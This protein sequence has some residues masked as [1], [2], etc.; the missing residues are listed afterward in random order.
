MA[1]CHE[2]LDRSLGKLQVGIARSSD[3]SAGSRAVSAQAFAAVAGEPIAVEVRSLTKAYDGGG[4]LALDGVSLSI[5]RG[6]FFSLLGPSGCGKTT[7]LR[8]IGGFEQLTSGQVLIDGADVGFAPPYLRSTN[9]IFQHLALFPHMNVFENIAFGLRRKKVP[10]RELRER[11]GKALVLVQL[12]EYGSRMADQLSGGQKQ[13]VAMARAMV[14]EPS[15]LLLDE[16]LASLDLQLRIQM[17]DE[18]RRLHKSSGRTFIYVTHDQG[19]A[20]SMSNRIGVMRAGKLEQIGTPEEI[21]N[22]PRT[23]FVAA[24]VGHTNL[25]E[26]AVSRIVSDRNVEIDCRGT[27]FQAVSPRL[28]KLGQPVTVALRYERLKVSREAKNG[29]L[30]AVVV[31]RT[32][33]GQAVRLEMLVDNGPGLTAEVQDIPAA[34]AFAKGDRVSLAFDASAAV[35]LPE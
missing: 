34:A 8:I 23:R 35:A 32:Y 17:Q 7:L 3:A 9:M 33:L 15:V 29:G 18:L 21:Y 24:F 11:V 19:E 20:M 26:G 28:L 25:L 14:N 16:P 6:E 12:G 22:Q 13:R 4:P 10:E 27:I 1:R 2:C 30:R 5:R 31:E